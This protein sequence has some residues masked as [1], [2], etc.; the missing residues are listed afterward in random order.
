MSAAGS[1]FSVE[2]GRWRVYRA[3]LVGTLR[4]GSI[5]LLALGAA[6][7]DDPNAAD[8]DSDGTV[9]AAIDAVVLIDGAPDGADPVPLAGFGVLTGMCG[10]L[11]DPELMADSAPLLVRDELTFERAYNDPAD[12]PLLTAG[13]LRLAATPNAG[14]SSGLSEI[15]AYEQLA[16]CELAPLLKTETEITYD[17][18]GKITDLLVQ[19]DGRKIGVSVT[20]AVAFPFGS[21]YTVAQARTLLERKLEDIQA[22]S[23]NVSPVDA[24][25][26]QI[27]AYLAYDAQAADALTTAWSQVDA[28]TKADTILLVT[29]TSGDDVFIYDND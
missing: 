13:G 18:I 24:W 8:G 16:R 2:P 14:G 17:T 15:F 26:K 20:R 1:Q 25:E 19:I 5:L 28:G 21:E 12:R 4:F 27:L 9:D 10:V 23:M 29:V 3:R 7:G 22:S 11:N 6:C